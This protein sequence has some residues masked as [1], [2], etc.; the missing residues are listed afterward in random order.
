MFKC[1]H[2]GIKELVSKKVFSDRGNKAWALLDDRALRT[3][4]AL[5]ERFGS[6]TVNDWQ[7]GGTNQ[8]RGLREPDCQIGA[9]YSQHRF[10]RAFDCVFRDTT[11]QAV[12]EFILD[13]PGEFPYLS[14]IEMGTSWLHFDVRNPDGTI[15]TFNP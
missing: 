13:N 9:A 5:R 2:F 3:L 6:I 4:D 10:G 1:K 12:R 7:W 11:A 15:Q 14:A 8:Y